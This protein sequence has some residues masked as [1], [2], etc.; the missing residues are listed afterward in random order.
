MKKH[1]LFLPC[2]GAFVALAAPSHTS[3]SPTWKQFSAAVATA[4][5]MTIRGTVTNERFRP[6]ANVAVFITGSSL[7]TVTNLSGGFEIVGAPVNGSLTFTHKDYE[8]REFPITKTTNDYRVTIKPL[9]RQTSSA[10]K[11]A[12]WAAR[13][14]KDLAQ[15]N[16]ESP[17]P[18]VRLDRWPNF[19]GGYKA[20]NKFLA[21]NL[22]YPAEA[23]DAGV[24]GQVLVSFLL[25]EE[26]NISTPR[27]VKTPGPE[28]DDEAIRIVQSMPRWVPAQ[29]N[30]KPVAVWYTINIPFDLEVDKLPLTV[31][32]KFPELFRHKMT[33]DLPKKPIFG[34]SDLKKFF[35]VSTIGISNGQSY[36][37]SGQ[38]YDS[39]YGNRPVKMKE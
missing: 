12:F 4:D 20:L 7:G 10:S 35:G 34:T 24:Q 39:R 18:E 15:N 28:L 2:L 1:L 27:V 17:D 33:F 38:S 36:D 29:K 37:I 13:R 21:N 8:T 9:N 22:K 25:D 5:T 14:Q 30:G 23:A 26:G 11:K 32:E 16:D 31:K 3:V 19:P 6:V